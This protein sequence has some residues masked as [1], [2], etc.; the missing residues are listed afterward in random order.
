M[1][2]KTPALLRGFAGG[3]VLAGLTALLVAPFSSRMIAPV[4]GILFL[5]GLAL[6]TALRSRTVVWL[7][8]TGVFSTLV[9]GAG[10]VAGALYGRAQLWV[11]GAFLLSLFLSLYIP[12]LRTVQRALLSALVT[13]AAGCAG[14]LL[15][16]ALGATL[17]TALLFLSAGCFLSVVS[18]EDGAILLAL[19]S[20]LACFMMGLGYVAAFLTGMSGLWV[21]ALF[22]L[23][24]LVS[25]FVLPSAARLLML[26]LVPI[27]VFAAFGYV[28][29]RPFGLSQ[30][31]VL[32]F[33]A[34]GAGFDLLI[35]YLSE[36]WVL[37]ASG[38]RVVDEVQLPE[39]YGRLRELS[40][41]ARLPPPRVAL[42]VSDAPN[43]LSAGR[44]PS[45]AVI[46]LSTGLLERLSEEELESLLAHELAHIREREL[47]PATLAAALASPVGSL[48]RPLLEERGS[49]LYPLI[50][51]VLAIAA[52][53]FSLLIH[54]SAPRG[55][56]TRADKVALAL[57]A[58]APAL[59]RALE[60]LESGAG[61]SH[62][63]ANPATA[64]LFAISP[65]RRGWVS[66]LF[67]SQPPTEERVAV[68]K[69]L[70]SGAGG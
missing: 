48:A 60:K 8:T 25:I 16:L 44:G 57:G 27:D 39:V 6:G 51:P 43:L 70:S 35:Y 21:P 58:S 59:A 41:R 62:L 1:E 13:V 69:R 4:S 26:L 17:L 9:M 31:L 14:A 33:T 24:V 19:H 67:S 65:F 47:A 63:G 55:R 23:S 28:L 12:V 2:E 3:V 45:R 38:A 54:L 49:E 34:C 32:V 64:H 11:S 50:I 40:S 36:S 37:R 61:G 29:G 7:M 42:M 15:G 30:G 68:L 52:P 53:F 20:V 22:I 46:A 56:E 66:A 10:H 18:S 5:A